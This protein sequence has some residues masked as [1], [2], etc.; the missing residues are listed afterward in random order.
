[1]AVSDN[2]T[3]ISDASYRLSVDKTSV[4]IPENEFV[5]PDRECELN[6]TLVS[7]NG[8]E[9]SAA[10]ISWMDGNQVARTP[11]DHSFDSSTGRGTVTVYLNEMGDMGKR[12]GT[13][14]VKHGRLTRKIK[15][16]TIR[17]QTFVPAWI[18][19]NI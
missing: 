18:T 1:M 5:L 3:A 8:G 11:F 4:V 17:R 14:L 12:E 7:L 10:E 15:I 13:L 19:T 2:I 9:V 6:Y 16:T